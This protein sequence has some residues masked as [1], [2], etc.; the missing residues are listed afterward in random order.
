M[1]TLED[2]KGES[3]LLLDIHEIVSF[4]DY[5]I[6]CS[7][8]SD[9]MLDSLANAVIETAKKQFDLLSKTEG[10]PSDGWLVVDLGDIIVHLFSPDQREYYHL[11]QLW[12]R[13]KVLVSLQ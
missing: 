10:R 5:F 3:I 2:K 1:Q 13:G 6:I 11:E 9:R 7:G 8:T 12:E 4:T